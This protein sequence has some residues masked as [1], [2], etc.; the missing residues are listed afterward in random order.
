[1]TP[2]LAAPGMPARLADG[3][4]YREAAD[5]MERLSADRWKWRS[6]R[7]W[8]IAYCEALAIRETVRAS[9]TKVCAS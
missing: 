8:S 6:Q 1:M 3:R 2:A 9:L 7:K 5:E 4:E